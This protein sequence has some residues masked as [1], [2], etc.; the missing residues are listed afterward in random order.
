MLN[1]V[2]AYED[3]ATGNHITD[4][5]SISRHYATTWMPIDVCSSV[6]I[7]FFMSLAVDG[8][9]FDATR[10]TANATP[11]AADEEETWVACDCCAFCASSSFSN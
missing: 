4:L 7:D 11:S 1:F 5:R 6:P 9:R 8:C 3:P 2:T 10:G